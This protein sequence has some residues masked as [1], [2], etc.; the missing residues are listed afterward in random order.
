[1]N[2]WSTGKPCE[3]GNQL[4]TLSL[5]KE[6][7]LPFNLVLKF[8]QITFNNKESNSKGISSLSPAYSRPFNLQILNIGHN[9]FPL[10][11]IIRKLE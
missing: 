3:N 6:T 2:Q 11:P 10:I 8:K 7:D 4:Y 5:N 9:S 1:M